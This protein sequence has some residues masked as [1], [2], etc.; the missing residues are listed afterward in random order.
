MNRH[1]HACGHERTSSTNPGR[2]EICPRCRAELR[3]CLNC[4]SYDA[5]AAEQCRDRR[6]E[7]V[8][9]KDRGNFCEFFQFSIRAWKG[10]ATGDSREDAAR[11][12]L[13]SLLG[14]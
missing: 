7:P 9:E 3:C 1:C 4:I 12:A 5:R 10:T 2:T 8:L 14:D 6:A 11:A 13:K